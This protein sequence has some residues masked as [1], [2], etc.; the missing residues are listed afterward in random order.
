MFKITWCGLFGHKSESRTITSIAKKDGR[1][2]IRKDTWSRC[3]R[4]TWSKLEG[5]TFR[6]IRR[7]AVHI[8]SQKRCLN[9]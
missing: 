4:C 7:P 9:E 5:S 1:V 8:P 2:G 6:Q 3:S